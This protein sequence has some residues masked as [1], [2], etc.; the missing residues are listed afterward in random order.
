[1]KKW[2]GRVSIV[3]AIC[4]I[5]GGMGS[6]PISGEAK[7]ESKASTQT[8]D[9]SESQ[10]SAQTQ[11]KSESQALTQMEDKSEL[12]TSTQTESGNEAGISLL[13][14]CEYIRPLSDGF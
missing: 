5:L 2:K 14:K 4:M 7:S 8:E 9:K 6:F 13:G 12:Q 10:T 11:D 1:M 3:L